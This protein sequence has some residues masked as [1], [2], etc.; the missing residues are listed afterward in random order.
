MLRIKHAPERHHQILKNKSF[1][2]TTRGHDVGFEWNFR[3]NGAPISSPEGTHSEALL[4]SSNEYDG[5]YAKTKM[6]PKSPEIEEQHLGGISKRQASIKLQ[7][8]TALR[9]SKHLPQRLKDQKPRDHP[10]VRTVGFEYNVTG[11][12]G[13]AG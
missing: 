10:G 1:K 6:T 12:P 7:Q 5:I 3:H 2:D 8:G 9:K 13:R 11:Q 4:I